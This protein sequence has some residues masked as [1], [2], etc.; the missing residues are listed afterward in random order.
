M[1]Y[2]IGVYCEPEIYSLKGL[3][4]DIEKQN[5]FWGQTTITGKNGYFLFGDYRI[6]LKYVNYS[7]IIFINILVY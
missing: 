1:G 6:Y 7:I 2:N 3:Q 5:S 4:T